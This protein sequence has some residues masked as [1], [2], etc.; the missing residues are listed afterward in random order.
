MHK[1]NFIFAAIL[2]LAIACKDKENETL[3]TRLPQEDTNISFRNL[4]KED[5]PQ[6]NILFYPYF[7]NGGGVVVGD[8]NNDGLTDV[9]FTGNMVRNR[10]FVN[11]G[12][13][14]FEDITEKSHLADK[15]GWCTGATMVDINEDGWLDIYVCRSALENAQYRKNLLFINNHDLTFTESAAQYGLDDAGFSTQAS[16]FDYDRDGD[17]DIILINQSVPKYSQGKIEYVQLHRQAADS[18]FKNKLFRNDAGHFTE[19]SSEAGI[20]SNVLTF[21]LGVSTADINQDG[22][23]DIYITNDFKEPDY[24]YINNKNGTF[25]NILSK[26]FDHTS[27]YA[28]G[29]DVADYN[30]DLLPDLI[31]LD[32]LAESNAAQK[33][34]MGGD[35]YTQYNY[36]FKSGMFHQYMKNC[37]QRNNGD[38]TFSEVAQLAGVS[39]TDWSWS[40]L[41]ADYD[42]DGLKD[43]FI[44]NGYKRDNTDIEFIIYSMNQSIR[45]QKGGDV[46]NVNE[47]ISH[48]PGIHIPN[49]IYQNAG[50]DRFTNKTK[51]WGFEHNDFSHGAVYA[52]LDNDGDLDLITNN[53]DEFAGVYRNNSESLIKNNYL[54][55]QLQGEKKNS[56]GIGTKVFAY[57][58]DRKFYLEQNPIRGFQSAS[59]FKLHL[60]LGSASQL[61]SLRIVWPDQ[62]TQVLHN[63]KANQL[64]TVK[65]AD[66]TGVYQAAEQTTTMLQEL[67]DVLDVKHVENQENDFLRQFLL[68]HYYSHNGPCMTKGD[69]NSDGLEDLFIGGAKGQAGKIFIQ[70]SDQHF[71]LLAVKSIEADSASEDVDAAFFDADSDRDLD[72]YVVS[73]GYEFPEDSPLLQD[74]LY[75]NNGKGNFIKALGNLPENFSNKHRVAPADIDHDGDVDLFIGGHVVPGKFPLASESA[76]LINDSKG[77]FSNETERF[78][79]T[80]KKIGIVNDALWT[81]I[82]QDGLQELV[83]ASEWQS[84]RAFSW[85]GDQLTEF[86]TAYFKQAGSGWWNSILA[87]DFD[88]DGDEDL[89]VGNYGENSQLQVSASHPVTLYYDDYDKNGSVDPIITHYIGDKAYPLIPRDDLNGQIPIMK[90][91]F[92]DYKVYA[93]STIHEI[94]SPE[95]LANSSVLKATTLSTVYLENTGKGFIKRMLPIEAQYAP[96]FKMVALDLN[97]DGFD[98]LVLAGNNDFNRIYLGKHDANHGTV[99]LGNGKGQFTYASPAQSGLSIRGDVRSAVDI[100][101]K[102]IF[103]VNNAPV[104]VYTVKK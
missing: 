39:N 90:K 19:V 85:K 61:D 83:I 5:N 67:T 60:G 99:L 29:L 62:K 101:N 71:K 87:H 57:A 24:Y 95:Q 21:S 35:N 46:V 48:M 102:L 54:Q 2:C 94:L 68:P 42:N 55:I 30:N 3:F 59:D 27:L 82:D 7:Y 45:L 13:F 78:G 9:F 33:M 76:I 89:I 66:V 15:E 88:E 84:L 11:Q 58:G 20:T 52:D 22:W 93:Q 97:H 38:G 75:L 81:D 79:S 80:L 69:I 41:L 98:D 63:V 34:H 43:L 104:K 100:D 40:P 96:V 8:I 64:L 26:A 6:F 72:L 86:D 91:K 17:L 74:R 16:F 31:I 53:T 37:L 77:K 36:L 51:E 103:G 18:T 50:N 12:K 92:S 47:Y 1:I 49:Y 25:T 10:L 70:T 32:M 73:G 28:M 14:E 4:L 65:Y 23:P 56:C 44:S